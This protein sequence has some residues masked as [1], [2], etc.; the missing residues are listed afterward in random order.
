MNYLYHRVPDKIVGKEIIP[1]NKL[2]K[3]SKGAYDKEVKK[4]EGREFL[5]KRIIPKLDCL[6]N[7]VIFLTAI[8][9]TKVRKALRKIGFRKFTKSKYF[10]I[11]PK[12]LNKEKTI[13]YLYPN[14]PIKERDKPKYYIK[15][16]IEDL[17]KY[18]NYKKD[19]LKYFKEKFK[20]KER[21]LL[22]HLVP[23]ILY[24]GKLKIKDLEI[25]EVK[26]NIIYK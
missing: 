21:P 13:I 15:F 17:K 2:K 7:D 12:L 8:H 4:Y 26:W 16:K 1:L 11:N 3:I 14:V 23:H 18:S 24:K 10:K 19:T 22:Y 20:A 5:L 6:W 25:I 9:P